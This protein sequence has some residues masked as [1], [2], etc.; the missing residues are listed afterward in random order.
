MRRPRPP[1]GCRAIEKKSVSPL[2][3]PNDC[4]GMKIDTQINDR[5]LFVSYVYMLLNK[6]AKSGLYFH[7]E[8]TVIQL[9]VGARTAQAVH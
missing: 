3:V 8:Y 2:T 6:S 5:C 9:I 7:K 4:P 1:R